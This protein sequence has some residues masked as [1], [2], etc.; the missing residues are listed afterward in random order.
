MSRCQCTRSTGHGKCL[1]IIVI[2]HRHTSMRSISAH[3]WCLIQSYS[4]QASRTISL[5]FT[6][7][8]VAKY[9]L[10]NRQPEN[11]FPMT[12]PVTVL[13]RI[14]FDCFHHPFLSVEKERIMFTSV[15][16]LALIRLAV[17][18]E[19]TWLSGRVKRHC[20]IV[21]SILI[22]SFIERKVRSWKNIC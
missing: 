14:S 15:V 11:S 7:G 17:I 4:W 8:V 22:A 20:A 18:L 2:D 12:R 5:T 3:N 21:N 1:L 10:V 13:R 9:T 16:A 6:N 19:N